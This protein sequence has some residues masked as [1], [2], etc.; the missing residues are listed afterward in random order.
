MVCKNLQTVFLYLFETQTNI[1]KRQR[2]KK[3]YGINKIYDYICMIGKNRRININLKT[4]HYEKDTFYRIDA[5]NCND[6]IR[7]EK[8]KYSWE[9]LNIQTRKLLNV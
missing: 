6:I 3:K 7:T 5:C 1:Q 2:D 8:Q 4:I 9:E